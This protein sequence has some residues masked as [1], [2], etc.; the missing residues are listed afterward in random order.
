MSKGEEYRFIVRQYNEATNEYGYTRTFGSKE[1]VAEFCNNQQIGGE[2]CLC[3]LSP[4]TTSKVVID[5]GDAKE[6]LANEK[7]GASLDTADS[8]KSEGG[9]PKTG[10]NSAVRN[11]TNPKAG[12]TRKRGGGRSRSALDKSGEASKS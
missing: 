3:I 5:W 1:E 4:L 6:N 12:T 7:D 11:G 2:I 8:G 10:K 9:E